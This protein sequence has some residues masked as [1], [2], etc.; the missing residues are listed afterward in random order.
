MTENQRKSQ[1]IYW[2]SVKNHNLFPSDIGDCFS[3]DPPSAKKCPTYR[4]TV[5]YGI[6]I[7]ISQ[8]YTKQT[9]CAAVAA[10]D[11]QDRQTTKHVP[12]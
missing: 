3:L 10:T 5:S 4:R 8:K 12:I 1:I 11:S 9:E 2:K 7:H 6:H